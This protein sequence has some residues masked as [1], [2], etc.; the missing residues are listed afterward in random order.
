MNL[1][2]E[3][4]GDK[5]NPIMLTLTLTPTFTHMCCLMHDMDSVVVAQLQ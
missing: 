4:P 5:P 1:P 2:K 3:R